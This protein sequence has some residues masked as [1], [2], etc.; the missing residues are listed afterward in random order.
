MP[1]LQPKRANAR[2]AA[3]P[4]PVDAPVIRI[5]LPLRSGA[6]TI[7]HVVPFNR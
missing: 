2:A 6:R 4:M 7:G 3:A 1:I 5:D